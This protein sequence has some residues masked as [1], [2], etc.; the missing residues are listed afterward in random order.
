M[1]TLQH[2]QIPDMFAIYF[3]RAGSLHFV[4][5]AKNGAHAFFL[6]KKHSIHSAGPVVSIENR[7]DGTTAECCRFENG[8]LLTAAH[9]ATVAQGRCC[10]VEGVYEKETEGFSHELKTRD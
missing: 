5:L 1:P 8:R 4:E 10:G 7:R 3:E 9:A 6:A 2:P